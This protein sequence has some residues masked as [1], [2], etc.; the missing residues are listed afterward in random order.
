MRRSLRTLVQVAVGAALIVFPV[1]A[2]NSSAFAPAPGVRPLLIAHRG[3][4]QTFSREG[5]TGDTCT[6]TRIFLPEHPYLENTI[7]SF[8]AAFAAG[9]DIVEFDVHPTTDGSFVVFHDWTLDCRTDGRGVTREHSLTELK[10]LDVGYGY[11]A[12][13][14]K[15][16]PFRGKGS[17][18][19]PTLDEVLVAFPERP[20]LINVKSDDVGEGERL[21]A[22]LAQLPPSRRALLTIYG[23]GKAMDAFHA[24]LPDVS[25]LGTDDVRPCL[26]KYA[27]MGWL[28]IVPDECWNSLFMLPLNY[29]PLAWGYPNRLAERLARNGTRLVLLGA[30]D[31]SG[32]SS[33]IDDPAEVASIPARLDGAIWTNRIDLIGPTVIGR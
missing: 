5:L 12:D 32:F 9:A 26:I 15:T 22:R 19:M 8:E 13:G 10:A 23:G 11:T 6:A 27:L 29:A 2:Y 4:G 20:F 7:A 21:A 31:G 3:L 14:G 24:A 17:G 16:Y 18:L 25:V 28:G 33:G 30:Y 1:L